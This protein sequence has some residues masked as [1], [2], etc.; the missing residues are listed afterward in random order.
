MKFCQTLTPI[1]M[2]IWTAILS[3]TEI[4]KITVF[5][6]IPYVWRAVKITEMTAPM[7]MKM[8]VPKKTKILMITTII[9]IIIILAVKMCQEIINLKNVEII[10][11]IAQNIPFGD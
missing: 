7:M 9:I 8:K 3:H 11:T 1:L 2:I 5:R 10:L 4:I 6:T